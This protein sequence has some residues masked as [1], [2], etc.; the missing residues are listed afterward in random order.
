MK[1][2]QIGFKA[3]VEGDNKQSEVVVPSPTEIEE[4][5]E[6]RINAEREYEE[7]MMNFQKLLTQ[8]KWLKII[9]YGICV[10]VLGVF[11]YSAGYTNGAHDQAEGNGIYQSIVDK[12]GKT[13]VIFKK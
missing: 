9:L 1:K 12:D 13:Y 2:S 6:Q 4:N 10:L 8:N 5:V 7:H 3:C 11:I